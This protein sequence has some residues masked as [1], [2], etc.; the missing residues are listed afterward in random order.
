MLLEV[1]SAESK[2]K[3]FY[4]I[5]R[6]KDKFSIEVCSG[7]YVRL[8]WDGV[9][10]DTVVMSIGDLKKLERTIRK[11]LELVESEESI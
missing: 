2:V 11:T 6:D 1:D 8:N 10:E 7:V 4:F 5:D 9:I 3:G